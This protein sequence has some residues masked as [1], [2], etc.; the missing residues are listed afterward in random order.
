[1]VSRVHGQA[2]QVAA[3]YV[4]IG[5]ITMFDRWDSITP[6]EVRIRITYQLLDASGERILWMDSLAS[7]T[8]VSQLETAVTT[9]QS[10]ETALHINIQHALETV[11]DVV[12]RQL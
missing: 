10:F 5:A 7:T 11:H 8:P 9:V 12:S 3:D 1:M 2:F 4:L 6:P